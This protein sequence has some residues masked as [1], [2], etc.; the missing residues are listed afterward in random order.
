MKPRVWSGRVVLRYAL[1]QVPGVVLLILIFIL[2]RRWIDISPWLF[3]VILA[4]W[5]TKDVILFPFVWRAYDWD[6]P[7]EG[8]SMVGERGIAKD[9]LSPSGY[10]QVRGELWKV[11]V[12]EGGHPI[13]RGEVVRVRG[14]RGLTLLVKPDDKET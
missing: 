13:E 10:V 12:M 11:E 14:I 9:R 7:K 8:N 1:L 4:L 3:W 2:A 5:V 6:R